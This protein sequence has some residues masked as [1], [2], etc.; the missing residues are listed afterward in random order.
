MRERYEHSLAVRYVL[1][2]LI[3][4]CH[5][6]LSSLVGLAARFGTRANDL[7]SSFCVSMSV[8]CRDPA[9]QHEHFRGVKTFQFYIYNCLHLKVIASYV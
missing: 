4:A 7:T 9:G 8:G 2:L 5:M 1:S 3:P 6:S